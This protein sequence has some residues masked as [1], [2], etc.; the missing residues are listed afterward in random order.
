MIYLVL[1]AKLRSLVTSGQLN[2]GRMFM[3]FLG[4]DSDGS[5]DLLGIE[6]GV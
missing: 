2:K 3:G 6:K 5:E 4:G 1:L